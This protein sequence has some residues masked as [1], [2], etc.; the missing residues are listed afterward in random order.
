[1]FGSIIHGVVSVRPLGG[2]TVKPGSVIEMS[3]QDIAFMCQWNKLIHE[4]EAY[5]FDDRLRFLRDE[6]LRSI[7]QDDD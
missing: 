1:M 7:R 2:E 5:G 3:Q 4:S 6:W